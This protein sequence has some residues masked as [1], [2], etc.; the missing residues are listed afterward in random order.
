MALVLLLI[1]FLSSLWGIY[2]F[3][4]GY[5]GAAN[6]TQEIAAALSGMAYAVIPYIVAKTITDMVAIRQR[7]IQIEQIALQQ[8]MAMEMAEAA[9]QEADG[10]SHNAE[11][12]E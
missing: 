12:S 7:H 1:S 8:S 4:S 11:V 6:A 9:M 5:S 3:I 2:V 10:G